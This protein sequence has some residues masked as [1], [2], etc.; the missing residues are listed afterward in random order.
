MAVNPLSLAS[1]ILGL[2]GQMLGARNLVV[3]LIKDRQ[4]IETYT[5][6]L[7]G[8]VVQLRKTNAKLQ[9]WQTE[10]HF[11][12]DA[13]GQLTSKLAAKYWS[14]EQ[15]DIMEDSVQQVSRELGLIEKI[16]VEYSGNNGRVKRAL[17]SES[18]DELKVLLD[19]AEN[20]IESL[21]KDA[22]ES[23]RAS[24]YHVVEN[25]KEKVRR[26]LQ[27][28]A[29]LLTLTEKCREHSDQLK[30]L[31]GRYSNPTAW[32][33]TLSYIQDL[34]LDLTPGAGKHTRLSGLGRLTRKRK[35]AHYT[36][37]T[38]FRSLLTGEQDFLNNRAGDPVGEINASPSVPGAFPL[39][40]HALS[41]FRHFLLDVKLSETSGETM[42]TQQTLSEALEMLA[43]QGANSVSIRAKWGQGLPLHFCFSPFNHDEAVTT[44]ENMQPR[45]RLALRMP[46]SR[47]AELAFK[48]VESALILQHYG[49]VD[50][51]CS[52]KLRRIPVKQGGDVFGFEIAAIPYVQSCGKPW[53]V[54]LLRQGLSSVGILLAEL[55]LEPDT[56]PLA[57]LAG[58]ADGRWEFDVENSLDALGDKLEKVDWMTKDS[59][60]AVLEA[61]RLQADGT[62]DAEYYNRIINRYPPTLTYTRCHRSN[63]ELK[64]LTSSAIGCLTFSIRKEC[65]FEN[66]GRNRILQSLV[67]TVA[68]RA[69]HQ[70]PYNPRCGSL[71]AHSVGDRNSPLLIIPITSIANNHYPHSLQPMKPETVLAINSNIVYKKHLQFA[72]V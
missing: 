15:C 30:D 46:P 59:A 70:L 39:E 26:A 14:H 71:R 37:F 67:D 20:N 40:T 18:L 43:H 16:L 9:Q 72:A 56:G 32:T 48:L 7:E 53:H 29:Y 12:E 6:K 55:A 27:H 2:P 10:W 25:E 45:S 47:K 52:C 42:T 19:S 3:Q 62:A 66:V 11:I 5:T 35:I 49:L 36:R 38:N 24:Y 68:F 61:M 33:T 58:L 34:T 63:T 51:L 22:W 28:E 21:E 57:D 13:P 31:G 65:Q 69:N 23:L 64:S 4:H 60:A 54:E 8:M 17:K 41:S 50:N 1:A 44:A